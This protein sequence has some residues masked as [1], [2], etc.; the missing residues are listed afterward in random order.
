[1]R[2][3]LFL[4]ILS[5]LLSSLSAEKEL[6]FIAVVPEDY[7]VFIPDD[8]IMFDKLAISISSKNESD[9]L[10]AQD[11]LYMG[12]IMN[13]EQTSIDF[14]MLYYGNL[15][16]PYE[17]EIAIDPGEGWYMWNQD[18]LQTLPIS[19]G[20]SKPEDIDDSVS[21][22]EEINGSVYATVMP[23]GPKSALPIVD[24]TMTW[25]GPRDLI[26][27]TFQADLRVRV[28]AI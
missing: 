8:V 6:K 28:S 15:G 7:G 17:V 23:T 9:F 3:I 19:V 14:S 10:L 22:S 18:E 12:E 26:P 13:S 16:V 20:Y 21:I 5:A 4:L 2:K 25:E 1:M 27:G 11:Q 24:V